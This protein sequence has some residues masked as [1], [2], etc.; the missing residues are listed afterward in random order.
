MWARAQE[1][2]GS[3]AGLAT[4]VAP[5]VVSVSALREH[6]S[7]GRD[8]RSLGTGFIVHGSG[9]IVTNNH[10]IDAAREIH[11]TFSDGSRRVAR[12]VGT[13]R[14]SDLALLRVPKDR[15]L[16]ALALGDSE[17]ARPGDW[18]VAIGSPFGLGGSV[19]AGVVSARNRQI[20]AEVL[21]DF[22]QTDVAINRGS[23][24]GPLLNLKGEVI[25]VNSA[26]MS[27]NGG[28]AGVSFAIPANTLRFVMARIARQGVVLRGWVGASALDLTPD[29]ATAFGVAAPFGALIGNVTPA[30]PAA[31]AGLV[32]GDIITDAGGVMVADARA[33]QRRIA[34]LEPGTAL[35]V[36]FLRKGKAWQTDLVIGTRP[37]DRVAGAARQPAVPAARGL[38]LGLGLEELTP[39]LRGRL[40]L[41]T[42]SQ[43]LH[44]RVVGV[45]SAAA[46][47][48]IR[49]GDLIVEVGQKGVSGVRAVK[50][51]LRAE[52]A[53]GK[54]FALVTLSRGGSTLFKALRLSEQNFDT[55]L[56]LPAR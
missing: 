18:V 28:S 53:A 1:L 26:L 19:S 43:G 11:V 8:G 30:G 12:L 45:A 49:T 39:A 9:L 32:P 29:L 40:G 33:F 2:P 50:E 36:S 3:V 22:I 55:A 21:E 41:G 48:D 31:K 47:A 25:G 13:D 5:S 37:A 27:P 14:A 24:G 20:E 10:V 16:Q 15:P 42:E 17:F 7:D 52:R 34:E 44:V 51:L 23:S 4:R 54:A 6:V 35:K 56:S 38:L 46:E